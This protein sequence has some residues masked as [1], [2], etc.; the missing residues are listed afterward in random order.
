MVVLGIPVEV[1]EAKLWLTSSAALLG[2]LLTR[3]LLGGAL[4]VMI[5]GRGEALLLAVIHG[6]Y[7]R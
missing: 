1:E 4:V 5:D 6:V 2:P 3:T 7:Q